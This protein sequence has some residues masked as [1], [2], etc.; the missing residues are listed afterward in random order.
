MQSREVPP[1]D[2][3]LVNFLLDTEAMEMDYEVARCRPRLTAEFFALLDRKIGGCLL[4]LGTSGGLTSHLT[5]T[6]IHTRMCTHT[7]TRTHTCVQSSCCLE[8]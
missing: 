3:D 5:H 2:H 4:A 6:H 8:V 7:H 1:D